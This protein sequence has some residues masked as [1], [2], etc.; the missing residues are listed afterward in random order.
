MC[1]QSPELEDVPEPA[2]SLKVN[3]ARVSQAFPNVSEEVKSFL[4]GELQAAL[5]SQ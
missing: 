1:F 4:A 5:Q 2:R 3:T